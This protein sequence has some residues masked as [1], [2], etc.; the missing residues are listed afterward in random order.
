MSIDQQGI[1]LG[2]TPASRR[3]GRNISGLRSIESAALSTNC[4]GRRDI[5]SRVQRS[6]ATVTSAAAG[7]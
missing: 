2:S 3:E 4:G 1:T 7:A 5:P 6:A